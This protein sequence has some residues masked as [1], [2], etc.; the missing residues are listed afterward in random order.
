MKKAERKVK[1]NVCGERIR[2]NRRVE[3]ERMMKYSNERV[4]EAKYTQ[5]PGKSFRGGAATTFEQE[6]V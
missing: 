2:E 1:E 3:L 5:S 4:V 6:R